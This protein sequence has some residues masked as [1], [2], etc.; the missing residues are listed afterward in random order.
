MG[1]LNWEGKVGRERGKERV[2]IKGNYRNFT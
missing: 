2:K 1:V